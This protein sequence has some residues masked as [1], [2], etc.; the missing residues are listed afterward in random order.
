MEGTE[1]TDDPQDVE[2]IFKGEGVPH[3]FVYT[4]NTLAVLLVLV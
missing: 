4:A 2:I 1:P 3:Y